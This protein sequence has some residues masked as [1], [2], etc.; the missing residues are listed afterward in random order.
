[1]TG[2]LTLLFILAITLALVRVAGVAL[3]LTGLP[4]PVARFQSIS[5]LTGTGFTTSEAEGTM[6]HPTRR[7][8]LTLLMFAGHLGVVSLASTVILTMTSAESGSNVV[9]QLLAMLAAVGVIFVLAAN[10]KMDVV[11]CDWVGRT[12]LR[13]GWIEDQPYELLY[14]HPDGHQLCEHVF[15][16][17]NLSEVKP[18]IVAVNG[19][20]LATGTKPALVGGD[21]IV[22]YAREEDQREW[23]QFESALIREDGP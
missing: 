6:H 2:A 18:H 19:A 9:W 16:E 14:E 1:M 8:I 12:L 5:A 3:R 10:K 4:Q 20:P 15:N 23:A 22:I 17:Q 7:R 13:A 11:M 21:R